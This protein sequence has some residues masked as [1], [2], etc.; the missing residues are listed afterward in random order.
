MKLVTKLLDYI[1]SAFDKSPSS[2]VAFRARHLSDA[3]RYQVSDNVLTGFDGQVQLFT[4]DLTE[5]TLFSLVAYLDSQDG[6][7][8]IYAA[9]SD[10]L[11]L[12][13]CI[14]I[15]GESAQ[16]ESNGDCFNA[17]TS[18]LWLWL[19]AISIQL[20]EAKQQ[21]S[22]MLDQTEIPTAGDEWLDE[23]GGYFGVM[24]NGVEVDADYSRRI[25]AEVTRPRGNNIAIEIAIAS[26]IGG[27]RTS[28]VDAPLTT[29]TSGLLR[30]GLTHYDSRHQHG[31]TQ[32]S[33]YGQFDVTSAFDITSS[34]S[35]AGLSAR[36]RATVDK[37]RDAG[38]HMRQ[39]QLTGAMS[40]TASPS[41][42][43]VVY[44]VQ[45]APLVDEYMGVR[46]RHDG[47]LLRAAIVLRAYSGVVV[48]NGTAD[49]RGWVIAGAPPFYGADV[50][51]L[52]MSGRVGWQDDFII[53]L[54]YSGD[55]QRDGGMARS[56]TRS[57]GLDRASLTITKALR[58]DGRYHRGSRRDGSLRYNQASR[59]VGT[60]RYSGIKT[61]S[62][63]F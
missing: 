50:D 51:S 18:L 2:F 63:A 26:A 32:R 56:G 19:N 61:W 13:A 12:S 30:D 17:Y 11:Q 31:P 39:L 28:V 48:R 54:Y 44:Q 57:T 60:I 20:S 5:H 59:M 43:V 45:Q 7:T 33:F 16:A 29:V 1:H 25:I 10:Q 40:D 41:S 22:N 3:F 49:R 42:D 8:V 38:T 52:A 58:R 6:I 34:E 24:R 4:V 15:D 62:E 27:F 36:I 37:F 53:P 55:A 23:W 35:L 9:D 14:L 21:I 46:A 47:T